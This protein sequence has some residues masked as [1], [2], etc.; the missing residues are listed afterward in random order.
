LEIA[1]AEQSQPPRFKGAIAEQLANIT[2]AGERDATI[3]YLKGLQKYLTIDQQIRGLERGNNHAV[4]VA[5]AL[6]ESDQT[7]E[8]MGEANA[9]T[10]DI[11]GGEFAK[12]IK[13]ADG[14]LVLPASIATDHKGNAYSGLPNSGALDNFELVA[15]VSLGAVMGLAFVGLRPRLREYAV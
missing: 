12:A 6:G 15:L 11:N 3:E 14:T 4:A 7:F 10:M 9:K 1:Q 8:A 5:I 2:F 13:S